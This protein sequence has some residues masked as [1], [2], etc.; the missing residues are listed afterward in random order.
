MKNSFAISWILA[1]AVFVL[2]SCSA[3]Q[4]LHESSPRFDFE[5]DAVGSAPRR[6]TLTGE[7]CAVRV[8]DGE[9]ASGVRCARIDAARVEGSDVQGDLSIAIDARPYRGKV[10]KLSAALR[11]ADG[12][13][14]RSSARLWMRVERSNASVGFLD[15]MDDA[16]VRVSTWKRV[17]TIG[18][19]DDDAEKISLGVRIDGA[20]TYFVDDIALETMRDVAASDSPLLKRV[21]QRLLENPNFQHVHERSELLSRFW[22][23]DIFLDAGVV[24]PPDA[25]PGEE[26][27]VCYEIHGFGGS[28]LSLYKTGAALFDKMR[29][30]Y[31]RMLYVFLDASCPQGHHEFVDS[32]NNGPWG[33][34]LVSELIPAIEKR[35][36][37]G[38][39]PKSRFLT[40]HSSGG[41]SSLWLQVSYPHL[42]DGTWSTAPDPVDFRN[43][44]GVDLYTAKNM[45]FDDAGRERPLVRDNGKELMSVRAYTL[46]EM[47]R[48]PYG[49]QMASFDAVFSPRGDDGR[50]MPLF[51][52]KT[53]VIDPFVAQAWRKFDIGALLRERWATSGG[54]LAGKLHVW[55]GSIDTYRLDGAV[56]LL[57]HDLAELGSDADVLIVE[58][59]AHASASL[60]APHP[61]L[62]PLGMKTRIHREMAAQAA[63]HP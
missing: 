43:F 25:K 41:W 45:Y 53:G 42:F 33:Q 62:W 52:R 19:V 61:V 63:L 15:A 35:F 12:L 23:R 8:Q 16:P 38:H 2:G 21:A 27:A 9:A 59:R 3:M 49:G 51:D 32:V 29:A 1:L 36:L 10:V 47:S 40:G 31:P 37:E 57:K 6:L 58:G 44:S 13:P 56:S 30:G 4:L 50:P 34:A 48:R 54:K 46:D 39:P 26:L 18:A 5:T 20:G 24:V 60:Y 14:E 11:V 55:C 22:G 7:N 28:W 17:E